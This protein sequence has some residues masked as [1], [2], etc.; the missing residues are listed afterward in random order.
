M[1]RAAADRKG[2]RSKTAEPTLELPSRS[3]RALAAVLALALFGAGWA[4]IEF[5]TPGPWWPD[6]H[7]YLGTGAR[8]SLFGRVSFQDQWEDVV[9]TVPFYLLTEKGTKAPKY[10]PG[11]FFLVAA[12]H[13]LAGP[14]ACLWINAILAGIGV[15]ITGWI[16]T[17]LYGRAIGLAGAALLA[18][19]PIYL[20]FA[21]SAMSDQLALVLSLSGLGLTLAL[22]ENRGRRFAMGHLGV[23][24]LAGAACVVRYPAVLGLAPIGLVLLF[25]DGWR[26]PDLK[27]ITVAALGIGL[28]LGLALG[29]LLAYNQRVFG[30]YRGAPARPQGDLQMPSYF[31]TAT[32]NFQLSRLRPNA[33]IILG[34]MAQPAS[35]ALLVPALLGFVV[36]VRRQSHATAILGALAACPIG[37]MLFYPTKSIQLGVL[38]HVLPAFPS[39][40]VFI[41]GLVVLLASRVRR[42]WVAPL[43]I[44]SLGGVGL[45]QARH[46]LKRHDRPVAWS[47]PKLVET[48][49]PPGSTIFS[50]R[51]KLLPI[52][53][54][55]YGRY[56]L[57]VIN[58][59]YMGQEED[60]IPG[61][62]Q[63][64][65]RIAHW[66]WD[67][68]NLVKRNRRRFKKEFAEGRRVFIL[69]RYKNGLMINHA[70]SPYYGMIGGARFNSTTREALF[71][72]VSKNNVARRLRGPDW[73]PLREGRTIFHKLLGLTPPQDRETDRPDGTYVPTKKFDTQPKDEEEDD[74]WGWF[75][76]LGGSEDETSP[77]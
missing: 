12:V 19:N 1:V 35:G 26:R 31:S 53:F 29:G 41:G 38:R 67:M 7:V 37:L 4:L 73:P 75:P 33:R 39:L 51:N 25:P 10:P 62:A 70:L 13:R 76:R 30:N 40:T 56:R 5:H 23:G 42:T 22:R 20:R 50:T 49:A 9:P 45:Y 52:A 65:F 14:A 43:L 61:R 72:V 48:F 17:R 18:V 46:Y 58:E 16:G 27:R 15:A 54:F 74:G 64:R 34:Q 24:L 21:N 6:E 3:H 68:N 28:G 11:F 71:E 55:H 60:P 66:E 59:R 47:I 69:F 63:W 57:I 44:L 77:E 32:S 2:R 36:L 8:L